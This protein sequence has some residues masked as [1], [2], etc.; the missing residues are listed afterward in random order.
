MRIEIVGGG[1]AGLYFAIL[2]KRLSPRDSVRVY[3]R[4]AENQSGGW[5]IILSAATLANMRRADP[6]SCAR[7]ESSCSDRWEH[8]DIIRDHDDL[9]VRSGG[10]IGIR[11]QNLLTI[12]SDRCREMDVEVLFNTPVSEVD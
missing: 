9:R 1:P 11:R 6:I 3:E 2:A 7:L 12:L 8:I 10:Y 5:G 4:N